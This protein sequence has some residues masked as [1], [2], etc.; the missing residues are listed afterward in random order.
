MK[1]NFFKCV[2]YFL[3][4]AILSLSTNLYADEKQVHAKQE[5]WNAM[6]NEV[7]CWVDGLGYPIDK[8]IKDLVIAL[9][10]LGIETIASCEG[11]LE[12]ALAYPWVEINIYP[13]R[14][15]NLTQVLANIV[16]EIECEEKNL[17]AHYPNLTSQERSKL[18][19]FKNLDNLIQKRKR[20]AGSIEHAQV[21]CLKPLNHFLERFYQ[22]RHSS[23]DRTLF[24]MFNCSFARLLSIGAYLQ[25]IRSEEERQAKLIEYQDEIQAFANFLKQQFMD[26]NE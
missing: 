11:H 17:K 4:A 1:A 2:Q 20:I 15:R 6:A 16:E 18:P 19:E 22:N 21:Q 8:G 9:N 25:H 24:V 10:L 3:I 23:Y 12:R 26:L 14:V 5:L 7:N 13:I